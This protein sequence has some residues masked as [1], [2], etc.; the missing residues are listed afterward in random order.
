MILKAFGNHLYDP[1]DDVACPTMGVHM[2]IAKNLADMMGVPWMTRSI[3]PEC[4]K[5][6][7][8]KILIR[9]FPSRSGNCAITCCPIAGQSHEG[10]EAGI[11]ATAVTIANHVQTV[12]GQQ[13]S[14]P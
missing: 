9:D 10:T 1:N 3:C 11:V 14:I 2:D 4:L 5:V 7:D 12:K 8:A 6:V 13:L